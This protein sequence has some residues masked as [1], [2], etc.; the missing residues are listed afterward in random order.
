MSRYDWFDAVNFTTLKKELNSIY[1]N[2]LNTRH[3]IL[4][5]LAGRE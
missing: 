5:K 4:L 3:E 1:S 2:L